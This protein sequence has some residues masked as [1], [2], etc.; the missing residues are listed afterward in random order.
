MER[1]SQSKWQ[2]LSLAISGTFVVLGMFGFISHHNV[3]K[4]KLE[5]RD[6]K[7]IQRKSGGGY[8]KFIEVCTHMKY[9]A[10]CKDGVFSDSD[11]LPDLCRTNGG[12]SL[13]Y[14]FPGPR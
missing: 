6:M 9:G 8:D 2:T 11:S 1:Y 7:S 3:D 5:W 13:I 14:H 12:V 4:C 10:L